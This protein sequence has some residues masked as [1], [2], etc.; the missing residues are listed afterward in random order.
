[1]ALWEAAGEPSPAILPFDDTATPSY[2]TYYV[3]G[4]RRVSC[5]EGSDHNSDWIQIYKRPKY[6]DIANLSTPPAC[7]LAQA[8]TPVESVPAPA[9]EVAFFVRPYQSSPAPISEYQSPE[10]QDLVFYDPDPGP[11]IESEPI[12]D[13]TVENHGLSNAPSLAG[14]VI[15]GACAMERTASGLSISSGITHTS[16]ST[17]EQEDL[18]LLGDLEA[19]QVV[20][21][22]LASFVR[23]SRTN[24][25]HERILRTL[26]NPKNRVA[27]FPI[28]EAALESIFSAANA[29]FFA[30]RLSNRVTWD[31]SHES[32]PQYQNSVIGTT[33]LRRCKELSGYEALIVL[34]RPILMS[35][36]FSRRLLISTFLHELIHSYLFISCGFKAK[37]AG[38]H[39]EGF[40]QIAA[41]I[42]CWAGPEHLR[43]R[44]MEADLESYREEQEAQ[45]GCACPQGEGSQSPY[46]RA[47][48]EL[49]FSLSESEGRFP[50]SNRHLEDRHIPIL[51][52]QPHRLLQSRSQA[53]LRRRLN[54]DHRP[55]KLVHH[56]YHYNHRDT[57]P[58]LYGRDESWEGWIDD[59]W[60]GKRP[61]HTRTT[62]VPILVPV[63]VPATM[64]IRA[65]LETEGAVDDVYVGYN[66]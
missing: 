8:P 43:L 16:S 18:G 20:R 49:P 66:T 22:H 11:E 30:S 25:R 41:M 4:K 28:D 31:W 55:Q 51:R 45:D 50:R 63:S 60:D 1:M 57:D 21:E 14:P 59:K 39:T 7:A 33:A 48:L 38:G 24:S 34:S 3:G 26:I 42:D 46:E 56:N 5:G 58:R 9:R 36:N 64:R 32:A 47:Q 35:K 23:R 29:I 54:D 65:S 17:R 40:H 10:R 12:F 6:A 52:D 19:A 53:S 62:T 44:E 13:Y 15:G 37:E 61:A 2:D 27:D